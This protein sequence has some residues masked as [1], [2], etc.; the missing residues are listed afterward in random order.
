MSTSAEYADYR[1]LVTDS[2]ARKL[3][4]CDREPDDPLRM[5]SRL[6][7]EMSAERAHL[8]LAQIELRRRAKAK[9]SQADVMFFTQLGL[10]QATDEWLAA[11]KASRFSSVTGPICDLCC[12]IGGDLMAFSQQGAS[13]GVDRNDV[14][15][16]L[17]KAN[18]E[19]TGRRAQTVLGDASEPPLRMAAWHIDPDRRPSGRRSTHVEHHEPNLVQLEALRRDS[20]NAAIKLAPAASLPERWSAEAELEWISRGGE[21]KQLVAWFGSLAV[22]PGQHRATIVVAD[23][24]APAIRTLV[25]DS[26]QVPPVAESFGSYLAEPDSAVLAAGLVGTLAIE[27]TLTAIAPGAVYLTGDRAQL[28]PALDWFEIEEV[29]AFDVKRLKA[30]LR[31]RHIGRLEIKQRGVKIDPETLRRQLSV[32]GD[33]A[34][35]LF[36][37]RRGKSVTALLTHRVPTLR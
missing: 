18:C 2:A 33:E 5:A 28:D 27:H 36:L 37:A 32:P 1:W 24:A 21:C 15:A 20:P 23:A 13:I 8:L 10:E 34:A 35:T 31:Q 9:F 12:G 3:A 19:V 11:Y 6:R 4:E 29:L 26:K 14:A 7:R 30:L 22:T 25:G 17:A 16:L